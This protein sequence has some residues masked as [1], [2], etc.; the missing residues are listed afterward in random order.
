VK[1]AGPLDRALGVFLE[2]PA[3]PRHGY[4]L[5]QAAGLPSGTLYPMLARLRDQGLVTSRWE[6][7]PADGPGRPPRTYYQLT[8]EG[9]RAAR[10]GLADASRTVAVVRLAPGTA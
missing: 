3:A 8:A 10:A 1:L 5:M 4:D 9:T 6:P 2:D 7:R